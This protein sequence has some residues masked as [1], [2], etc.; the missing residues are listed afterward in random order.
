M[1]TGDGPEGSVYLPNGVVTGNV[2][3]G[4]RSLWYIIRE[5]SKLAIIKYKLIKFKGIVKKIVIRLISP[6]L[7]YLLAYIYINKGV[8]KGHLY[9]Q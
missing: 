8:R 7:F 4:E 1:L 9:L 6:M 2:A 3:M 5:M